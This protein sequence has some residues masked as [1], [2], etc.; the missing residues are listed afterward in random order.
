MSYARKAVV[1]ALALG[2][3]LAGLPAA[4][5]EA[6]LETTLYSPGFDQ[7]VAIQMLSGPPLKLVPR[8]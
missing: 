4:A 1:G 2:T 7:A 3:L 8:A 6:Q 5:P